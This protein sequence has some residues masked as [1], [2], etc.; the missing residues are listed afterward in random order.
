MIIFKERDEEK[1]LTPV[2]FWGPDGLF[3][4]FSAFLKNDFEPF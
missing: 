1:L 2:N 4:A 3:Q